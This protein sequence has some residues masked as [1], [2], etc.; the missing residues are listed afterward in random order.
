MIHKDYDINVCRYE[1]APWA[2]AING[3][4]FKWAWSVTG[5]GGNTLTGATNRNK[6]DATKMAK[7]IAR[8]MH[9]LAYGGTNLY[10]FRIKT[11]SQT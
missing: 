4:K 10:H 11:P 8:R 3:A 6:T 1:D 2:P 5:P 7:T 9:V